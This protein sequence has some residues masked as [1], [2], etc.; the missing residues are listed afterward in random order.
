MQ[1]HPEPP[2]LPRWARVLAA[3]AL[4][5]LMLWGFVRL[6]GYGLDWLD[7]SRSSEALR[8]VYYIQ[9]VTDA[10]TEA[11]A[12]PEP[13]AAPVTPAPTAIPAAT[14]PPTPQPGLPA[15][16]YPDN[17]R[18][19]ISSRF[20]SLRS[21][22]KYIVGWLT[23]PSLLDE[24]VAQRDNTYY[25]THDALGSKNVNGAIFLDENIGLKT[26][27]YTLILYGHNMKTGAMFGSLR[28][29]ET[30]SFYHKAPLITFDTLYEEGRY[31]IFAAG[32][33]GTEPA[34]RNFVD[35]Y[36]LTSNDPEKRQTAIRK[37]Q[38]VSVH[39]CTV[40]VQPD[41]QLLLLVTCVE[42]DD[43]RR[44]IAARRLRDGEDEKELIKQV[45]KSRKK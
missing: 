37:L 35:F 4:L 1:K 34:D 20:R 19:Q 3:L 16:R 40:D 21:K 7:S 26:R 12:S 27:P 39:T 28:N 22:S 5:G 14:L 2:R 30:L 32:S 17:P 24:A 29:Y 8:Q 13:T 15:V 36:A 6:A 10:P 42:Q 11:P 45:E 23:V 9:P 44:V 18:L 41:D 31:V 25:L 38:T 33:I 43:E